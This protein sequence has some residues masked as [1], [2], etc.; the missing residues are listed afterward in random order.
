MKNTD[1]LAIK[2]NVITDGN[3]RINMNLPVGLVRIAIEA[4]FD[5]S[6][7]ASSNSLSN[8]D[9]KNILEQIDEGKTGEFINEQISDNE[10]L[11]VKVE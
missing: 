10:T 9:L 6:I 4:G 7:L 11:I 8:L 3:T 2:I 5:Q 1:L